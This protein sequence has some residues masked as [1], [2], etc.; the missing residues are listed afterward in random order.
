MRNATE[1]FAHWGAT[2]QWPLPVQFNVEFYL[3]LNTCIVLFS[4]VTYVGFERRFPSAMLIQ[5]HSLSPDL[6]ATLKE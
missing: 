2:F 3:Q 6:P 5:L 4:F 1:L